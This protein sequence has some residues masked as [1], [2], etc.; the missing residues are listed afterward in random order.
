M[1][2]FF[3]FCI[4]LL[5]ATLFAQ[6]SQVTFGTAENEENYP[7]IRLSNGDFILAGCT[8]NAGFGGKDVLVTR[9]SANGNLIWSWQYGGSGDET[10]L[11]ISEAAG[12][13]FIIGGE[14]FSGDPNGDAFLLKID[15]AGIL[16]WWKDYGDNLY[17]ITYSVSGLADGS[18]ISA[19][20]VEVAPLDYDAFLMKTDANGDTLWTRVI[21][22]PGIEHAVN[23]IQT[24]DSGYIF[25]GK[26]LGIGQGVCECWVVK[27]NS[28]GDTVWT[29]TYGG[30]GWDESMDIIEQPNGYIVC[31]GTNSEGASNYDFLLMHIDLSGN[32]VWVKQYG[33]QNVEASYCVQ[34]VPNEGY[35]IAGYTETYSYTN[36]RGNDS[37]NAFIVKTNYNGD[38]LWSMVY[39]GSLKEE[40]FSIAHVPGTGYAFSG[41]TQSFGD[42][43]QSYLFITDSAGYT[44]CLERRT[45]PVIFSPTFVQGSFAFNVNR[46][47][48]VTTPS[49]SQM[50]SS[51]A[52]TVE[53]TLPL[54]INDNT[55]KEA[56]LIYPNP[57]NTS[58]FTV[59]AGQNIAAVN[60]YA[61]H[62]QLIS[63][64]DT[65]TGSPVNVA[66][67]STPAVAGVYIVIITLED[68]TVVKQKL[69]VTGIDEL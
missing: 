11:S 64:T 43:L 48:A 50:N 9:T 63:G 24:S 52:S 4:T 17:D 12:G 46:G 35:V 67:V 33:G 15:G 1:R 21:G 2:Y 32:L 37:A 45:A 13:G 58:S 25:C 34:E 27:T 62:G 39:G 66:I 47:Y 65:K 8:K 29:R 19:G 23:V 22:L 44:G 14:S 59:H 49:V 61:I 69:V 38:T 42:S 56:V 16:Q 20:L 5:S 57:V 54:Q 6:P 31:G 40:C 10:A 53:C 60:V 26:A 51:A 3:S 36:S 30:I 7:M 68:G 18:I 55:Q 28:N 41:Y